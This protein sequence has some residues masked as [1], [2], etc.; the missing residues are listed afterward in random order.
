MNATTVQALP[1][2]RKYRPKSFME[3]VGQKTVATALQKAIELRRIPQ[4]ILLTGVRG[5]GKTTTARLFA[6]SV[7]CQ[8]GPTINPCGTCNSC[9]SIDQDKHPDVLEMDGASH[10]GVDD[11]RRIIESVTYNPQ[12]SEYKVYIIDEVHMLSNSAFNALLK[13]LEEPPPKVV[14]VFA[15]TELQKVPETIVSRCQLFRLEKFRLPEIVDRLSNILQKEEIGFEEKAVKDI[16]SVAGGSMRDALMLLDQVI[17]VGSGTVTVEGTTKVTGTV[18]REVCLGLLEQLL[19]KKPDLAIQ[20]ISSAASSGVKLIKICEQTLEL[21]RH[22]FAVPHLGERAKEELKQEISPEVFAQIES[23]AKFN[24]NFD[25]NRLF[26]SLNRVRLQFTGDRSDK[27]LMENAAVEWCLDPGLPNFQKQAPAHKQVSE[28]PATQKPIVGATTINADAQQLE[29]QA[30]SKQASQRNLMGEFQKKMQP[31]QQPEGQAQKKKSDPL[32]DSPKESNDAK[33]TPSAEMLQLRKIIDN[34][35]AAHPVL[36]KHLEYAFLEPIGTGSAKLKLVEESIHAKAFA[37]NPDW[38]SEV[39][40][41]SPDIQL[42][43]ELGDTP[44]EQST[45]L[46]SILSDERQSAEAKRIED[47]IKSPGVTQAVEMLGA[48]VVHV[49][50]PK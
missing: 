37:A 45:T 13:T 3:L 15:T 38:M 26:R 36:A 2:A 41:A 29:N 4:A 10:T 40:K 25:S 16:A 42:K 30:P 12:M 39:Q 27:F 1:L 20:T 49:E 6:K 24:K 47:C 18:S 28:K 9:L 32:E 7:V 11:A 23:L 33:P 19:E 8:N 50:L 31:G 21:C 5:I 48:E 35:R 44:L 22:V 17:A 43:L 46:R 14:F 34:L